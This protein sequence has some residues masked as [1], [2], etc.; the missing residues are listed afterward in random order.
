MA[1]KSAAAAPEAIPGLMKLNPGSS[2]FV[3]ADASR[4]LSSDQ[5]RGRA[6]LEK[7]V[8]KDQADGGWKLITLRLL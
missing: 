7:A 4:F 8:N 5:A 1:A 6:S 2:F 3:L